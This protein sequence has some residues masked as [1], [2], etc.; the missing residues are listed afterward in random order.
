MER[1]TRK[2]GSRVIREKLLVEFQIS[3]IKS[4][5]KITIPVEIMKKLKV[6]VGDRILWVNAT[7]T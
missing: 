4:H 3:K 6:R 2:A 5:L 1:T 7:E